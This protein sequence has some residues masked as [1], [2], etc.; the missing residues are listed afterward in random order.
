M[1]NIKILHYCIFVLVL[2]FG[3]IKHIY[4]KK[5]HFGD[6]FKWRKSIDSFLFEALRKIFHYVVFA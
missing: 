2:G 1:Q 6:F 4:P 3:S 5:V